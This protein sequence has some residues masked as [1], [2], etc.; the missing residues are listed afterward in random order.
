M[1]RMRGA[2]GFQPSGMARF[3]AVAIAIAGLIDPEAAVSTAARARVAIVSPSSS[4]RDRLTRDLSSSFDVV[5]MLTSDAAAAIVIGDRYPD[6][7]VPDGMLVAR[8]R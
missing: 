7:R 6:E 4:V 8:R 1:S 3:V 5:P 2:R